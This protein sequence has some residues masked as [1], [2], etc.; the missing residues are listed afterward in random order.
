MAAEE[1]FRPARAVSVKMR[2]R[3]IAKLSIAGAAAITADLHRAVRPGGVVAVVDFPPRRWLSW[4]A[5]VRRVPADRGGHGIPMDVLIGEMTRAGF[6]VKEA[7]ARWFLDV[8]CVVFRKPAAA[9]P[10]P[11]SST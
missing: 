9:N 5:P 2:V 10:S 6:L 8:Y 7:V 4:I 1:D 3:A 11:R